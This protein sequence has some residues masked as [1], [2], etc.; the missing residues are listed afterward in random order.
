VLHDLP[1]AKDDP[2]AVQLLG[3]AARAARRGA[4]LTRKLLAFSRRQVLQPT[5]VDVG[6]MLES[7]ADMLRRTLDQRIRIEV[8]TAGAAV[9]RADP[10]QL[11][12]ALLNIAIN[13]RDAMPEG[14]RLR[15]R[16]GTVRA[17]PSTVAAPE[18]RAEP[19][20]GYVAISMADSGH[21]MSEQV[22]ER[23]L[24]PFFTTKPPGRGTGLGLSTV[25]GFVTQSRGAIGIEST[26]GVGTTVTLYIPAARASA[27]SAEGP[28]ANEVPRGL[29][30]LLVEDDPEVLQI[31]LRFLHGFGCVVTDRV[32]AE[33]ARE[34]LQAG[35]PCDLLMSDIAL[36]TGMRGTELAAWAQERRP[37]LGVLLV[38]GFSSELVDADRDSPPE[39]E[40]LGKPYSREDLAG[41]I[42]RAVR[43][44]T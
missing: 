27:T 18:L 4:E 14:G 26:V 12:S 34:R 37:G 15:F 43:R 5:A 28:T 19:A 11:E 17:L 2:Q 32:T 24:E 41:A 20:G 30:V 21:G 35:E 6:T 1:A 25:Y 9:C 22:R 10:G 39:W 31:A 13:A 7:L 8:E 33:A 16:A 38:S 36:G 3:A 40:L 23:A 29:R 42:A 44:R